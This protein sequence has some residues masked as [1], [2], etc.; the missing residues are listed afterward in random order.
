[1][2]TSV[3]PTQSRTPW[4]RAKRW[5]H[6]RANACLHSRVLP[7]FSCNVSLRMPWAHQAWQLMASDASRCF[8]WSSSL[9]HCSFSVSHLIWGACQV[10]QAPQAEQQRPGLRPSDSQPQ[11]STKPISAGL[12]RAVFTSYSSLSTESGHIKIGWYV[13]PQPWGWVKCS[14]R[15]QIAGP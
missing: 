12:L 1:M 3:H 10:G 7:R 5:K 8:K 6:S 15:K 13:A 9:P 2:R 4:S 11:N 14:P